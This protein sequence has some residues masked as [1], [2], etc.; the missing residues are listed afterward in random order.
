MK[1]IYLS[2]LEMQICT[3]IAMQRRHNDRA[4]GIDEKYLGKGDGEHR[5]I[6]GVCAEFAVAKMYNL[7]PDLTTHTRKGGCDLKRNGQRIDVK[8]CDREDGNLIAPIFKN[9]H[10]VDV[11]ILVTGTNPYSV[12]GWCKSAELISR[13][14]LRDFGYGPTYYMSR[15]GLRSV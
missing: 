4:A 7:Y 13:I 8:Q 15:D 11:Y 5:D 9:K 3:K 6:Q 14:N 10:E 2:E 12:V 1:K